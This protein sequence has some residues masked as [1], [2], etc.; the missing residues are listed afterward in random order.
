[1]A[2]IEHDAQLLAD[3]IG[4]EVFTELCFDNAIISV[5]CG[6]TTPHDSVLG[7]RTVANFL[8][9]CRLVNVGDALAHVKLC[10][11]LVLDSLDLDARLLDVLVATI[12]LEAKMHG[13]RV[14]LQW[15]SHFFCGY[16]RTMITESGVDDVDDVQRR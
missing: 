6:D 10:V 14:Q 12:T 5:W 15:S 13:S 4:W 3:R 1:M 8:C 2:R 9:F 16:H 7:G 11:L